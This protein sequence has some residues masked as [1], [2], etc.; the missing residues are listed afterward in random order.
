MGSHGDYSAPTE[1]ER[2]RSGADAN[3]S[4]ETPFYNPTGFDVSQPLGV[5]PEAP[6]A[7]VE[8]EPTT[9]QEAYTSPQDNPYAQ[10]AYGYNPQ[11]QPATQPGQAT[12][13]YQQ[14]PKKPKYGLNNPLLENGIPVK[15][16]FPLQLTFGILEIASGFFCNIFATIF[17]VLGTV[18][19][20]KANKS[21]ED[22]ELHAFRT[23]KQTATVFLSIG[24]VFVGLYLLLI[25]IGVIAAIYEDDYD[26][27]RDPAPLPTQSSSSVD[28]TEEYESGDDYITYRSDDYIYTQRTFVEHPSLEDYA[29]VE[30]DGKPFILPCLGEDLINLGYYVD[31]DFYEDLVAPLDDAYYMLF[32]DA[33]LDQPIANIRVIN[34][35][36]KEASPM[37]LPVVQIFIS[38]YSNWSGD[39]P[40]PMLLVQGVTWGMTEEEMVE[41]FGEADEESFLLEDGEVYY[42]AYEY[43]CGSTREYYRNIEF[44]YEDGTLSEVTI[45]VE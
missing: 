11:G 9:Q 20:T 23:Q 16:N 22:G 40:V 17:G 7:S 31:D 25:V 24:G 4:T 15:H 13:T 45:R 44:I 6:T 41:L 34:D 19:A 32:N 5:T 29:K 33:D 38:D 14:A 3:T 42:A 39:D 30:F 37:D 28:S 12:Y 18:F 8:P 36:D 26:R 2:R 21:Y 1:E 27:Y 35:G 43:Y 10:P